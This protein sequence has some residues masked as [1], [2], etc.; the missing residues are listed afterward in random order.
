MTLICVVLLF[1]SF[2]ILV[3]LCPVHS[4]RLVRY[5]LVLSYR[6]TGF[7]YRFLFQ[8]ILLF[9]RL[10]IRLMYFGGS[11]A[12]TLA[13]VQL[14]CSVMLLLCNSLVLLITLFEYQYCYML[15]S[16]AIHP[17]SM[18]TISIS[19]F[20]WLISFSSL[21]TSLEIRNPYFWTDTIYFNYI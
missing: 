21:Y 11:L 7:S 8:L 12:A 3:Y 20:S 19:S 2:I 15:C 1:L 18:I 17:L 9:W 14:V 13:W 10:C 6:T 5:L 16:F 4:S